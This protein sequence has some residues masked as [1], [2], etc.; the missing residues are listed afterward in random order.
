MVSKARKQLQWWWPTLI[1]ILGKQKWADLYEA[2]LH[3]ELQAKE[4]ASYLDFPYFPTYF[5][6]S[7]EQ[8]STAE[9]A[10]N[11]STCIAKVVES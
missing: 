8:L 1:P 6:G 11:L 4:L 9:H 2:K 10:N 5:E 3:S 7:S